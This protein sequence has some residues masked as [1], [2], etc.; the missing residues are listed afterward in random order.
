MSNFLLKHKKVIISLSLILAVSAFG[1]FVFSA[2]EARAGW[3]S[4]ADFAFD[5]IGKIIAGIGVILKS[6]A[7]LFFYL[8]SMLLEM[9]FGLEKFTNAGIVQIGWKITRDVA[10]MLFVIGLIVIAGATALKIDSYDVKKLLPKL[11]I[12]ALLINFSLVIAGVIIDF[13]QVATHFFYEETKGDLGFSARIAEVMNISKMPAPNPEAGIASALSKGTSGLILLIFSIFLE[14][15][16]ILAAAIAVAIG[17]FF[18]IV[19]M[20][21]LWILLILAPMAWAM[22]VLPATEHLFKKW[23]AEFLK[24]S[25]FAPV[26]VFFIYL[27]VKAGTSGVIL[28]S[29]VRDVVLA[30]GWKETL[31]SALFA[32]PD[33]FMQFLVVVGLLFGG[34]IVAQKLG[35]YGAA[36][37]MKIAKDAGKGAGDWSKRKALRAGARPAGWA[38]EKLSAAAERMGWVGRAS[39]IKSAARQGGRGF[40][41]LEEKE[42]AAIAEEGKKYDNYTD[43][44]LKST[45]K[46]V[47]ARGKVAIA[48]ILSKR[49][50][51]KEDTGL[52]F[53][54][55]DIEKTLK[56]A[57]KYEQH[58]D[59]LKNRPDLAPMVGESIKKVVSKIKPADLENLQSESLTPEV[60][61]TIYNELSNTDGKWSSSHLSKM[62]EANPQLKI[63]I[64][65][66]FVDDQ[67]KKSGLRQDVRDYI[68]SE[69]G[70]AI[71]A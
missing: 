1:V 10:N 5:A 52:G 70:K 26:Y 27:A 50:A 24:W 46:A 62:A 28:D 59:I 44:N 55:K 22:W 3:F 31:G 35:G 54:N 65:K 60:M 36:G 6:I 38:G 40:R 68:N 34:V 64:K 32:V 51:L 29:A 63:E 66:Q 69:A 45:Y 57:K 25:F 67:T 58:K 7:G 21:H 14:T 16:L 71:Y 11:I 49:G 61:D 42:R 33:L 37:V 53:T 23:W 47:D 18:M 2:G 8:V 12:A 19:R 13:T 17:A 15:I 43:N 30:S 20:I 39:G 4:I 9:A 56:I 48:K 41:S